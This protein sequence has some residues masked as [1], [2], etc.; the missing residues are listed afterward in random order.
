MDC[1]G[2]LPLTDPRNVDLDAA[3]KVDRG[4]VQV[5]FRHC[6][7]EVELVAR[8]AALEA[9][10]SIPCQMNRKNASLGGCG[11]VD[12]ARPTELVAARFT[13]QEAYQFENVPH[14]NPLSNGLKIDTRQ[15]H[16][17]SKRHPQGS[18]PARSKTRH[19]EEEPVGRFRG[20][21]INPS[22][23]VGTP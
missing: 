15:E 23:L 1:G 16:F 8:R 12:R 10:K 14:G 19:R 13:G 4:G 18:L 2:A 3:A 11:A 20:P 9:A 17:S 6:C 5:R 7:P 21:E 22:V